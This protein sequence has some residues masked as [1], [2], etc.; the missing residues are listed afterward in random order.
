MGEKLKQI[1]KLL[2]DKS[3]PE[4]MRKDLERKKEILLNDKTVKK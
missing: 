1:E 4:D 3:L 2:K